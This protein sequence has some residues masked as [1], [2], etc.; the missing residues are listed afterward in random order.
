MKV[1]SFRRSFL[2]VVTGRNVNLINPVT[3]ST[4]SKEEKEEVSKK[5][6]WG[7]RGGKGED[8][9]VT[10]NLVTGAAP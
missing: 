4:T 2:V 1:T 6:V 10:R 7:G 8:M 5:G 3:S 9:V